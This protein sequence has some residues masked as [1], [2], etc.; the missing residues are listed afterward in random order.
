M[1][2]HAKIEQRFLCGLS[3]ENITRMVG[4]MSQLTSAREAEKRWHYN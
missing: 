4:A 2:M 1:N 3:W